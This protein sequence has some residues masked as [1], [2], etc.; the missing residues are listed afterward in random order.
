MFTKRIEV[1]QLKRNTRNIQVQIIVLLMLEGA[2]KCVTQGEQP[3]DGQWF[4]SIHSSSINLMNAVK[5]ANLYP[6]I[7]SP[8]FEPR[9]NG[10]AV[11]VFNH[12]TGQAEQC[13]LL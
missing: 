4:P 8:G 11:S 9:P 10:T 3:G 2:L 7:P 12:Y 5:A 13:F 6:S 1:V